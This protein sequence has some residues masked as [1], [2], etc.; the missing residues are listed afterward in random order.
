[1]KVEDKRKIEKSA[2][3]IILFFQIRDNNI[4][5][6]KCIILDSRCYFLSFFLDLILSSI[7]LQRVVRVWIHS[8]ILFSILKLIVF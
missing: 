2:K 6:S 7:S 8:L 1:M 3:K 5:Y 4:K